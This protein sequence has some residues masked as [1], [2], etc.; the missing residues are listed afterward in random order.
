MCF[1]KLLCK[2]RT[3]KVVL[4]TIYI[5]FFYIHWLK[6]FFVITSV[7]GSNGWATVKV[8]RQLYKIVKYASN[9]NC[10]INSKQI[11]NYFLN[12]HKCIG[13]TIKRKGEWH[14]VDTARGIWYACFLLYTF[15]NE[16]W[17]LKYNTDWN[18]WWT[19]W[20]MAWVTSN[21]KIN[22]MLCQ[23]KIMNNGGFH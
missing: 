21:W 1:H 12:R 5:Y 18:K 2:R 15:Q 10:K 13:S 22:G 16:G 3:K 23:T 17:Q 4:E 19:G 7:Q 11:E 9:E 14:L 20:K 6:R 8:K